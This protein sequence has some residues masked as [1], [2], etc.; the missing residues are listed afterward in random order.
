MLSE[1]GNLLRTEARRINHCYIC[2]E[3]TGKNKKFN[4]SKNKNILHFY[5]LFLEKKDYNLYECLGCNFHTPYCFQCNKSLVKFFQMS[6]F[7]CFLCKKFVRTGNKEVVYARSQ[8]DEDFFRNLF[9]NREDSNRMNFTSNLPQQGMNNL[10]QNIFP[11]SGINFHNN[12][13]QL[14][15]N[16]NPNTNNTGNSNITN[17]TGSNFL[18]LNICSNTN[19][20]PRQHSFSNLN[21]INNN[22]GNLGFTT[23]LNL[24]NTNTNITGNNFNNASNQFENRNLIQL[25][26]SGIRENRD[27]PL[28]T[29]QT[30]TIIPSSSLNNFPQPSPNISNQN[31]IRKNSSSKTKGGPDLCKC[32]DTEEILKIFE[33]MDKKEER[34]RMVFAKQINSNEYLSSNSTGS[35]NVNTG[36]LNVLASNENQN[37][38]VS[39]NTNTNTTNTN[40]NNILS[41]H[42]HNNGN[43]LQ[44]SEMKI[45]NNINSSNTNGMSNTSSNNQTFPIPLQS[46][47]GNNI[48][49]NT[50]NSNVLSVVN[51]NNSNNTLTRGSNSAMT[52]SLMLI[53]QNNNNISLSNTLPNYSLLQSKNKSVQNTDVTGQ[54]N[55]PFDLLL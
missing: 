45:N 46:K 35:M 27:I 21:N 1:G 23:T 7:M 34:G 49:I 43:L 2:D 47:N 12:N 22:L 32:E 53:N 38:I 31:S 40:L 9:F 26:Q 48:L 3:L 41:A 29:L 55:R 39:N 8:P 6:Y 11:N 14:N 50:G 28:Q 4:F 16:T 44:E 19:I 13:F 25:N 10:N 42:S 51:T 36:N 24:L 54:F 20:T 17:I 5:Q 30:L 52:S 15:P 18:P 37:G 33:A